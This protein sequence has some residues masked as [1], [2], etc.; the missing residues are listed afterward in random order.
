[1]IGLLCGNKNVPAYS[2]YFLNITSSIFRD[3]RVKIIVFSLNGVNLSQHTVTG[4]AP[5]HPQTG[6]ITVSIPTL[7]INLSRQRTWK[8][9]K[10]MR[11]LAEMPGIRVVNHVNSY[12]QLMLR[13]I[14]HTGYTKKYLLP[15]R[16]VDSNITDYLPGSVASFFNGFYTSASLLLPEKGSHK[17]RLIYL[18]KL[19][20]GYKIYSYKSIDWVEETEAAAYLQRLL[21]NRRWVGLYTPALITSGC[22]VRVSRTDA[23]KGSSGHWEVSTREMLAGEA[24]EILSYISF[25]IPNLHLSHV[26]F[27]T[28]EKGTHYFLSLGGW[29]TNTQQVDKK[30]RIFSLI[31]FVLDSGGVMEGETSDV[32]K[33]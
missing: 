4:L 5:D 28:D 22:S 3:S 27:I 24:A 6:E 31:K 19:G 21:R 33:N 9:I 10:K 30:N 15:Y 1:M 29:N 11:L 17:R 14:L 8:D 32:D 23:I 26:N 25:F 20:C 16:E 12:N 18:V 2:S 7:I 13:D